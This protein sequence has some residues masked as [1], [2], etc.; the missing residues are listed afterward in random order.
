MRSMLLLVTI[1]GNLTTMQ[2]FNYY[3][4][5]GVSS[6]VND[7]N[8][9]SSLLHSTVILVLWLEMGSQFQMKRAV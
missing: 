4:H 5:Y 8:K 9:K 2:Y 6:H 3:K 7:R 1:I